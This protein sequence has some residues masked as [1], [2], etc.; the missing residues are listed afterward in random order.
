M[1]PMEAVE[2][3]IIL[4]ASIAAVTIILT[5]ASVSYSNYSRYLIAHEELANIVL[6]AYGFAMSNSTLIILGNLGRVNAYLD[7]MYALTNNSGV[8]IGVNS[9]MDY[10]TY[11]ILNH[12]EPIVINGRLLL[13]PGHALL[14]IIKGHYN[15]I[16]VKVCPTQASNT[17][18]WVMLRW[19]ITEYGNGTGETQ[20]SSSGEGSV[21]I[22][23]TNDSLGIPWSINVG[24]N[25]PGGYSYQRS[26]SGDYAWVQYST[27]RYYSLYGAT[28]KEI[29]IGAFIMRSMG[30]DSN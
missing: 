24:I 2:E 6:E 13:E 1:Q 9:I 11:T 25:G 23:I 14:M 19:V 27:I 5:Y 4:V 16:S 17:C 18:N 12:S 10:L 28:S 8:L 7:G 21:T 15:G 26:G 22:M 29:R 20:A 3:A 30:K